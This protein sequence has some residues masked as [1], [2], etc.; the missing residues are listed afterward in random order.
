MGYLVNTPWCWMLSYRPT[1]TRSRVQVGIYADCYLRGA[2]I[3]VS[4]L[5]ERETP[6]FYIDIHFENF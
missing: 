3:A 1:S 4:Q 6:R 5:K 2:A